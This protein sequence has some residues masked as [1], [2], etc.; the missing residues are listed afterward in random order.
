MSSFPFCFVHKKKWKKRKKEKKL[1]K[2]EHFQLSREKLW[3]KTQALT[4]IN[5]SCVI[6]N[7]K[8]KQQCCLV[9]LSSEMTNSIYF[10]NIS[11]VTINLTLSSCL[12]QE[13]ACLC[14]TALTTE[15]KKHNRNKKWRGRD[16]NEQKGVLRE[17]YGE[18][19]L[20]EEKHGGTQQERWRQRGPCCRVLAT[21]QG[22]CCF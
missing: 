14:H 11:R 1:G 20:G 18:V 21:F 12:L 3:F 10:V 22:Q 15:K 6:L 7:R 16:R 17:Q 5:T 19:E 9:S 13:G 2:E 4:I 8:L